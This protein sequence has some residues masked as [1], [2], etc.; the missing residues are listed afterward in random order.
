[1]SAVSSTDNTKNN[2]LSDLNNRYKV[3][4][5]VP[6]FSKN[7]SGSSSEYSPGGTLNMSQTSGDQAGIERGLSNIYLLKVEEGIDVAEVVAA[8]SA[9]PEVEYAEPNYKMSINQVPDDVR[10]SDLWG[11]QNTGQTGGL[12]DADIDAPE[13]WDIYTGDSSL[14]VGVIDTGVDYNHED[15]SANMWVNTMEQNGY[16]EVDDD[17]NG[18]VDDIYGWDAFNDEGDPMDDNNHGT[19][20]S[21]TIGAA[22]N[23]GVGVAGVNWNVKIMALKYLDSSGIGNISD[24]LESINYILTMKSLGVNIK[25]TNNS[26][27]GGGYSNALYDAIAALGDAGILFVAAAGNADTDTDITPHYPTSYDLDNIVAVAATDHND[28]LSAESSCGITAAGPPDN[29]APLNFGTANS[30]MGEGRT[31]AESTASN[32]GRTSIDVGAPGKDIL[33]TLPSNAYSIMSGTSMAT[34]HVAGLAALV[35]GYR[36]G[37]DFKDVKDIIMTTVDPLSSLNGKTRTSGR[38]NAWNALLQDISTLPPVITSISPSQGR[39]AVTITIE[40][41]RFGNTEGSVVFFNSIPGPVISWS[42]TSITCT[43]PQGSQTGYVTVTKDG[44][45][46]ASIYFPVGNFLKLHTPPLTQVSW[47]SVAAVNGKIYVIGG[48]AYGTPAG[49]VQIYDPASD[50]WS[51]GT[52][53]PTPAGNNNAAVIDDKIYIAGGAGNNN[54]V[55]DTLEIYDPVSDTWETGMP[56]PQTI[57]DA[58]VAAVNGKLYVV[59]GTKS[60]SLSSLTNLYEYNP[61]TDS[62]SALASMSEGRAFHSA[63][64]IDGKIYVAGGFELYNSAHSSAEVYDPQTNSWT[65][66][67]PMSGPRCC[68]GST[69]FNGKLYVLGGA[70][71][72]SAG[73][74]INSI[75]IYDTQTDSWSIDPLI[76]NKGRMGLRGVSVNGFFYAVGGDN[77]G[78]SINESSNVPGPDPDIVAVPSVLDYSGVNPGSYSDRTLTLIN[79]GETDLVTGSISLPGPPFSV[80]TDNCSEQ[81]LSLSEICDITIRF[82]PSAIGES[83]DSINIPSNDPDTPIM[84]LPLTGVGGYML[85]VTKDGSGNGRVTSIPAGI[86]CGIDCIEPYTGGSVTLTAVSDA[87]SNFGGW[88]GGGCSGAGTCE[89]TLDADKNITAVFLL[90]TYNI[91]AT[92]GT[93]GSISPVGTVVLTHGTGQTF[94]IAPDAGYYI[95]D[96]LVDGVSVGVVEIYTFLN[97]T[98][99]HTIHANFTDMPNTVLKVTRDGVGAGSVTSLPSGIDCG[100]DC[101]NVYR[102]GSIVTL[103]ANPNSY[104]TLAGWE[105]AGCSGTGTCVVTMDTDNSVTALFSVSL[106]NPVV[107]CVST[108]AELQNALDS[109]DDN[110]TNDVIRMVQGTYSGNFVFNNFEANDIMIEGGYTAG[111]VSR[112]SAPANTVM[113]GNNAGNVLTISGSSFD[114]NFILEG[115]TFQNGTHGISINGDF[116]DTVIISNSIISNNSGSGVNI[117]G[118]TNFVMKDNVVTGNAE[119]ATGGGFYIELNHG[120]LILKDNTI[121]GNSAHTGAGGYISLSDG[122][123]LLVNNA[124]VDNSS[125]YGSGGIAINI[126]GDEAGATI[127][128]NTISNNSA[129][130]FGGLQLGTSSS[131]GNYTINLYNNIIWDN[132]ALANL[133]SDLGVVSA[134]DDLNIYYNDF[135]QSSTAT[136]INPSILIDPSNMDNTDPLFVDSFSGDYNLQNHSDCIDSGYNGAPELTAKD[137]D[138]NARIIGDIVD[139][140][141]YESPSGGSNNPPVADAGGPYS[142]D[143]DQQITLNGSGSGD[144]DGIIVLYEW[145][146]DNDGTYDYSSI[147]TEQN[148]TYGQLATYTIKLR[149]TDNDGATDEVTTTAII[150]DSLPAADFT[151]SPTSGAAPLTVNFINNS[152]GFDQP[153]TYEWDFENDGN[154]DSNLENPSHTYPVAGIYT[155]KLT[156]FDSDSDSNSLTITS[157]IESTPSLPVRVGELYY[158]SIQEAYNAAG[159]GDIIKIRDLTFT[160]DVNCNLIKTVTLEGGYDSTYT[161]GTEETHLKGSMTIEKGKVIV[162]GL[163]IE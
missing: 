124:I 57:R 70:Q 142:A 54:T 61:V 50:S 74:F 23:N 116:F 78:N 60:L 126:S 31:Y 123:V 28:D 10:F 30:V 64:V 135:D 62:W 159:D 16:P 47:P 147:S 154:I 22:G 76:L 34:P 84:N 21:G 86:D 1:M 137:R 13:A 125:A 97:V 161:L 109:A 4:K 92:A 20:V 111:C 49:L 41:R 77:Y 56:L 153:L 93:N 105:G 144:V 104:S 15:L 11:Q 2:S 119:T 52:S 67:A 45:E 122:T 48:W 155:V 110:G 82:M 163:A 121:T 162:K 131:S 134:P 141:A 152:T 65:N 38:I 145:D 73:E 40:G 3:K 8:Y 69:V 112:D 102:N 29:T 32:Y 133:G 72:Y 7:L 27:G 36:P 143:Q 150:T 98:A 26:W 88:T 128:N 66:V 118:N 156:A 39:H 24:A 85:N 37:A 100:T 42:D 14:V 75:E 17:G 6:L 148:H 58:A 89:L 114:N 108:A 81:T 96:V 59:G 132:I 79:Y 94:T 55:F 5:A 127:I 103:S 35:W 138:G 83:A 44:G 43:V 53:K 140:G 146:I 115:I 130:I 63:G 136:Y 107:T 99:G 33:S 149:V 91:T 51:T 157:Y 151:G 129:V 19:H 95:E 68:Q 160:E 158:S 12:A 101:T 18:Y 120:A 90:N 25:V 113:D 80:I 71:N 87:D 106:S 46:T 9:N 117:V 139:M